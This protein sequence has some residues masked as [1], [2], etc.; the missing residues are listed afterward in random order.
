MPIRKGTIGAAERFLSS[1]LS[2]T[3]GF[4]GFHPN[5]RFT[6]S[7]N[8]KAHAMNKPD[9]HDLASEAA[10]QIND[11]FDAVDVTKAINNEEFRQLLDRIPI[12]IIISKLVRGDH[13]VCYANEAFEEVIGLKL[14]EFAGRGWSILASF[15]D[16]K[17]Q[18]TTLAKSM[19]TDGDDFL[20]TFRRGQPTALVV[21][22]F[23]GVIQQ[24]DGTEDYRIAALIDVTSRL[25]ER[26]EFERKTKEQDVLLRELQHRVKNNLQLIVALIRLEARAERRGERVNLASLAGRIDS[27]SIIYQA[28][29]PDGH[30]SELDLGHY[31]SQIASSLMNAYATERIR[32][33]IKVDHTPTS[34]N[35]ALPIGLIVNELMTNA[36]KYAFGDRAGGTITLHC[37]RQDDPEQY[38]VMVGDDGVGLP[39][40]G[41]WPVP[42]KIGALIVQALHE[43]TKADM[44][45]ETKRDCG[46]RATLRFEHKLPVGSRSRAD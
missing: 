8:G 1:R 16:E 21:E 43:N 2:N 39:E 31:L 12:P 18:N 20:G 4:R 27:L 26:E 24:E 38:C 28:L 41:R 44:V 13:R 35:V 5:S 32:L 34:I 7:C 25:A 33:D 19:L 9:P 22:A 30:Q 3:S 6:W 29:S 37:L 36:F 11:L 17:D 42:G 45:V 46:V 23:C 15:V 14:P 10:A 40:G